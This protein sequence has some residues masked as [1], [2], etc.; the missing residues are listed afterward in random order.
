MNEYKDM[1]LLERIWSLLPKSN[2]A[3]KMQTDKLVIVELMLWAILILAA[4][5]VFDAVSAV[6]ATLD[7]FA[8]FVVSAVTL[9]LTEG[10][11]V[12]WR[13]FRCSMVNARW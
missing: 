12:A 3:S 8:R 1:G 7:P 11:F 2:G 5:R 9:T 10:G 13:A 6:Y 4:L